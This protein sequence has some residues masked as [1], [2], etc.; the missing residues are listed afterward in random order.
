[1]SDKIPAAPSH[2]A[3]AYEQARAAYDARRWA[4]TV[5]HSAQ[6]LLDEPHHSGAFELLSAARRNLERLGAPAGEQRILSVLMCD[7]VDSARLPRLIGPEPYRNLLLDL[8]EVCASAITRYEGRVA[9]YL[10][11]GILAYFSYPQAHEDDPLR[12]ALAALAIVAGIQQVHRHLQDH[13]VHVAVRIGIDTGVV[14]VGAM[15]AGQWTTADSIVGDPPNYAARL[16]AIAPANGIVASAATYERIA[17]F[18]EVR[19]NR[20]R[21]FKGFDGR[22]RTYAVLSMTHVIETARS[23]SQRGPLLGRQ[24]EQAALSS[25][26]RD[27]LEGQ[28]R[29]LVVVGD[30]GMGKSRLAD[31]LVNVVHA[32]GGIAI[33]IRCSA[34]HRHVP[35]HP[36]ASAVRRLLAFPASAAPPTESEVRE[37][38]A[39]VAGNAQSH[40]DAEPV[41]SLLGSPFED[42]R[43]P[44]Q[45][46]ERLLSTLLSLVRSVATGKRFLVLIEDLHDAD[47][48]TLEFI[49]R[50]AALVDDPVAIVATTRPAASVESRLPGAERIEIGRLSDEACRALAARILGPR[51]ESIESVVMRACGSPLFAEELARW[52]ERGQTL[53]SLPPALDLLLTARIDTVAPELRELLIAASVIGFDFDVADLAELTDRSR[54]T[55]YEHLVLLAADG[56]VEAVPEHPDIMRRFR[57]SLFRDAAYQRLLPS[58]RARRHLRLAE[59]YERAHEDG[60]VVPPAIIAKH[61]VDGGAPKRALS[62]WH[63]AAL[64][65]RATAAHAEAIEH[66][67]AAIALLDAIAEPVERTAIELQLQLGVAESASMVLGYTAPRVLSAF[68]RAGALAAA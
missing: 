10:G 68:E 66:Y 47:P 3:S 21:S 11:D 19:R 37:R 49:G 17:P 6:V 50:L 32:T 43:L 40:D 26:W 16:Q 15:G 29:V 65:A 28:H 7:L 20:P 23:A 67:D 34:L 12:A 38:L 27:V 54:A 39:T 51:Q 63:R 53:D 62:W 33:T 61:L 22:R 45:R 31:E 5:K 1:M 56:L 42:D 2:A 13:V 41:A 57:H 25:A 18:I 4:D 59:R 24:V 46:R 52:L 36:V 14:V 44:E 60:R 48:S 30:A 9:Q 8:Q 64:D 35:F 58:E 55:T